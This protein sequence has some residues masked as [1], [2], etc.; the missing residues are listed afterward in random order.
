MLCGIHITDTVANIL[1]SELLEVPNGLVGVNEESGLVQVMLDRDK[2]T[3]MK[4]GKF[5]VKSGLGERVARDL[6]SKLKSVLEQIKGAELELTTSG[7]EALEVYEHGPSSCMK[8]MECVKAYHSDSVAVA[9][10]RIGERIVARSVVCKDPDIGLQYIYIYG[11]SDLLKP[12]LVKAGYTSGDLEGCTLGR[13]EDEYGKVF[14]PYLDCGTHVNDDGNCIT[15]SRYGEYYSQNTSGYLECNTCECCEEATRE[16]E[17]RYSDYY[18]ASYCESCYEDRHEYVD[19]EYYA[20]ESDDITLLH[21]GSWA[22]SDDA[23]MV[24]R[25]NEYYHVDE[26]SFVKH[27]DEY[28]PNNDVVYAVVDA[29]DTEEVVC[30]K[31]DCDF[32]VDKWVHE[33]VVDAY[34]EQLNLEEED[35]CG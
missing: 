2:K 17:L 32:I 23:I 35:I 6:S 33:D 8:G 16:D 20:T 11:N 14:L 26:V 13:F 22:M 3:E 5:L 21:N 34:N 9:F 30:H 31:D 12:L 15:V 18:E 10:V 7:E 28:I 4:F 19:G 24:D 25:E 1:R 29:E 27:S